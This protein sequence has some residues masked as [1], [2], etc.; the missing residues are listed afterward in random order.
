MSGFLQRLALRATGSVAML[1]P[2]SPG[3]FEPAAHHL[4]AAA[5]LEAEPGAP[6]FDGPPAAQLAPAPAPRAAAVATPGQHAG[7]IGAEGR[8]AAGDADGLPRPQ[9]GEGRAVVRTVPVVEPAQPHAAAPLAAPSGLRPALAPPATPR[10]ARSGP[11]PDAILA[12]GPPSHAARAP[13]A[14]EPPAAPARRPLS[15]SAVLAAS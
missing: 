1:R 9:P 4:P 13:A 6:A 5:L 12:P 3:L 14:P 11:A 8:P 2:R 10:Q 7:G 15:A